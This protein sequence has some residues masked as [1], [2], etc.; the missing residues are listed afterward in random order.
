M[1][2]AGFDPGYMDISGTTFCRKGWCCR[3]PTD[4]SEGIPPMSPGSAAMPPSGLP[5]PPTSFP[6]IRFALSLC[7]NCTSCCSLRPDLI[8]CVSQIGEALMA[9]MAG[10]LAFH[11]EASSPQNT[12]SWCTTS[13]SNSWA[14]ALRGL[15]CV[16]SLEPFGR[17]EP[18]RRFSPD[19]D[20]PPPM[21]EWERT[22]PGGGGGGCHGSGGIMV[23]D[24]SGVRYSFVARSKIRVRESILRNNSYFCGWKHAARIGP[25]VLVSYSL[26]N[27]ESTNLR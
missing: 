4:A 16:L 8:Q 18:E 27:R 7:T 5:P 23:S 25:G 14:A 17:P 12:V 11:L 6:P 3:P 21:C 13:F 10:F 20:M 19:S 9:S 2:P 15:R 22:A 1:I 26:R 24:S